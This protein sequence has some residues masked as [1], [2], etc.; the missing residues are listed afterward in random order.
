MDFLEIAAKVG[1]SLELAGGAYFLGGS[2]ASSLQGDPRSTNDI[3]IVTDLSPSR[4]TQFAAALGSDF[5]CDEESLKD[6]LVR[7]SS[8][9]IYFIPVFTKIDLFGKGLSLFDQSEF[10][11]RRVIKPIA[12]VSQA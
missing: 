1:K 8:W 10:A 3:D 5:E 6:A 9:D 11:R 4:V 12:G 7:H 2:V